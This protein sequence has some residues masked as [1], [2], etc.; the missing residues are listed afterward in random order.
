MS[1]IGMAVWVPDDDDVWRAGDVV[2]RDEAAATLTVIAIDGRGFEPVA[3]SVVPG[4]RAKTREFAAA[5]VL[6]RNLFGQE[7]A[8]FENVDDLI[9]LPHLNEPAILEAL[10]VRTRV[11][12]IYTYT[13]QILIAVNPFKPLPGIYEEAA[14]LS[15]V[16]RP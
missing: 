1:E 15:C 3:D 13:G 8:G 4:A 16:S 5:D 9:V 2:G 10:C 7:D 11:G 12:K 14:L 6:P